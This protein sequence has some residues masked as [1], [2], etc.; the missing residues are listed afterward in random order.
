MY[1]SYAGTL[2][3]HAPAEW[4]E[5]CATPPSRSAAVSG[6]FKLPLDRLNEPFRNDGPEDDSG[7]DDPL[8]FDDED[9]VPLTPP[10]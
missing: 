4:F 7:D 3:A 8:E 6:T 9:L 2:Y 10:G 1:G 5:D